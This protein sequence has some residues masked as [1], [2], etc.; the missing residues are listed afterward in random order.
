M[1]MRNKKAVEMTMQTVVIA[2]L[3]I[4]VLGVLV[5]FLFGGAKAFT[6]GTA[7]NPSDCTPKDTACDEG[8]TT[9]PWKCEEGYK[10]CVSVGK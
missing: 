3:V 7:C 10:C 8:K 4:L 9:S 6:T 2:V 1:K 5:Y